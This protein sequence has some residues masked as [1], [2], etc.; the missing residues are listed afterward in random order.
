MY[1]K[2]KVFYLY[3]LCVGIDL[4]FSID[5]ISIFYSKICNMEC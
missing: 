2:N 4:V 5:D 1:Y 3:F